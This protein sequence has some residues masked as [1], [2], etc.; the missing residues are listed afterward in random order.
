MAT[1][2]PQ[3][4][5]SAGLNA[6]YNAAANGDK[7]PPGVL[8]HVKNASGSPITVTL[9]TVSEYDGIALPDKT[10]ASIA[11]TTGMQFIRVPSDSNYRNP[12]DGLVTI[13]FSAT[14][15]VTYAVLS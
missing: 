8:L 9:V 12:A 10:T 4:V 3:Q 13:N 7:V 14:T 2:A 5:T 15:S 11:A 1:Y 6:T